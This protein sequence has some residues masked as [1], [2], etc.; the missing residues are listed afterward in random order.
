MTNTALTL[1][2]SIVRPGS[3]WIFWC[4]DA[5]NVPYANLKWLDQVQTKPT[6]Q[7]LGY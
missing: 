3:E 1:A 4:D 7:E 6:A 5:N 2:L